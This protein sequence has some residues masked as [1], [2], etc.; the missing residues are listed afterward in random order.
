MLELMT[1]ASAFVVVCALV[2]QAARRDLAARGFLKSQI[3]MSTWN[4]G[5]LTGGIAIGVLMTWLARSHAD[6][7]AHQLGMTASLIQRF[8]PPLGLSLLG[9]GN[10][11][12]A[13]RLRRLATSDAPSLPQPLDS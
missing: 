13:V 7:I 9:V 2:R 4:R 8:G 3:D 5:I 6:A 11:L 12:E 10:L 1:V